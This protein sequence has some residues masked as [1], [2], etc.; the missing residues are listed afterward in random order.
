MLRGA[1][2]DERRGDQ[3]FVT[4]FTDLQTE[5]C[6]PPVCLVIGAF[7]DRPYL[8]ELLR[9]VCLN[10][11]LIQRHYSGFLSLLG[12]LFSRVFTVS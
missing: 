10:G 8:V 4:A 9:F 6:G 12:V 11:C 7:V 3:S 1:H 2:R 5:Y